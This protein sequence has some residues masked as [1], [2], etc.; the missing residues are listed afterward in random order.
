MSGRFTQNY[1]WAEVHAFLDLFGTLR[2]VQAR[3]HMSMRATVGQDGSPRQ[4]QPTE[5]VNE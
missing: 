3:R 4:I 5:A 2:N 1:T